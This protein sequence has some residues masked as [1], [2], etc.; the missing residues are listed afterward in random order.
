MIIKH[1]RHRNSRGAL[2][3][4]GFIFLIVRFPCCSAGQVNSDHMEKNVS[5]VPI[6]RGHNDLIGVIDC[7]PTSF[8]D[9][10]LTAELLR[11]L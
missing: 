1:D 9:L 5:K 8:I 4:V 3:F 6:S 7:I 2:R 10:F 11:C